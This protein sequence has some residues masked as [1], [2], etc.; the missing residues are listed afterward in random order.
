MILKERQPQVWEAVSL[1]SLIVYAIG[2]NWGKAVDAAPEDFSSVYCIRGSEFRDWNL[3]KG[4]TASLRAVKEASL[5]NRQLQENDILV[6]ISGGGPE[7]PVG[8]TVLIDKECLSFQ[9][10]IPKIPTNFLR[11]IRPSKCINAKYL[12]H[13]LCFFYRSGEV[14]NYQAG[15]NNLRNLKFKDYINIG[16][17]LP[18]E[19]EQHRIV[20]KIEELFS[21]LDKGIEYLKTAR[22]QLKI[23]RQAL[24]KQAFE[25]K[26]TEQWRKENASKLETAEQLLERIK[27]ERAARYQQQ[28]E[29]WK[30]AVKQWVANG[31]EGKR[32]S[33]PRKPK[34]F[35]PI[36][37]KDLVGLEALPTGWVYSKFGE[38]IENSQNGLSKRNSKTGAE[39]TVLRLA[40]ISQEEID[41]SDTRKIRLTENEQ[42]KYLLKKNDLLCIRVNG[43]PDLVG[44]YVLVKEEAALAYCDHFIRYRP[45]LSLSDSGYL[46]YY[47]N[48][49]YVR[50]YVDLNKVSSAG[51]N[52]VNQDTMGNILVAY[53]GIHEQQE[54]ISILEEKLSVLDSLDKSMSEQLTKSEALRQSI[55]KKAFSGQLVPQDPNDEP[56]SVLLAHIAKEKQEAAA[57]AKQVKAEKKSPKA[58]KSGTRKTV[59]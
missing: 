26:L 34:L 40:D 21:E 41:L 38:L 28:L 59:K 13:Y 54:I 51:Q 57:R 15:S 31:K 39:T 17:P 14:I 46:K 58:R 12:N 25:G 20:A 27:Q 18:P 5:L 50:R 19:Y 56:A 9:P 35:D 23:Y 49:R 2:G 6:E 22:K 52:T 45:L 29:D 42:Q 30:T 55:L 16:V 10:K 32:P 48:T 33:K 36:S 53:C 4:N 1:E 47:F 24:L 11:L 7:Q 44:R 3:D 8:R 43:S 37:D